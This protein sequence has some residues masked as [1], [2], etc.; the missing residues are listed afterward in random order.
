MV[1]DIRGQIN[2]LQ[3]SKVHKETQV[4]EISH[5]L[6]LTMVDGKVTQVLIL[7]QVLELYVQCVGLSQ[8]K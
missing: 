1:G 7:T 2:N 5:D 6:F 3:T 4:I 8:V